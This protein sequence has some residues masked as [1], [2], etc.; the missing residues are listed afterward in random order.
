VTPG[1]LPESHKLLS[2]AWRTGATAGPEAGYEAVKL[3]AC[4]RV[5]LGDESTTVVAFDRGEAVVFMAVVRWFA[6]G[7]LVGVGQAW[8]CQGATKPCSK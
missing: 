4:E 6:A 3:V 5:I 8:T 1:L 7:H 2:D